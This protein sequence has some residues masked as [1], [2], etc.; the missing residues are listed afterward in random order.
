MEN[1][2]QLMLISLMIKVAENLKGKSHEQFKWTIEPIL[3]HFPC[4]YLN[5]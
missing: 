3:H 5:F 1:K 2:V 4:S